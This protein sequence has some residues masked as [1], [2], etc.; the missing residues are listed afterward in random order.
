MKGDT[1]SPIWI[2]VTLLLAL[3]VGITMYQLLQ[4]TSANKTFDDWMG[5]I[6][7]G[8]AE[9]SVGSFCDAWEGAG[10]VRGAVN[11]TELAKATV[12]A[13]HPTMAVKYFTEDEFNIGER[14]SP[15]DCAVYL[16]QTGVLDQ[17]DT[18]SWY[19]PDECHEMTND[20]AESR[21]LTR[22]N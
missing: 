20:I 4:K 3:V 16:Y 18:Q 22:R 13:A 5:Q 6:N 17:L 14:L 1:G 15:C 2:V 12:A 11:P 8:Q 9:L 19:D 21:G 10:F 7:Q